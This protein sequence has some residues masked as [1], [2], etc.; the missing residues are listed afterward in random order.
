MKKLSFYKDSQTGEDIVEFPYKG[1]LL[2]K[3]PIVNK[4]S[5]FSEEE[6]VSFEL[7]GLLPPHVNTIHIQM[8]RAY[9][10][11]KEASTDLERHINLR[12]LQD[13]NETLFYAL[14]KE[15]ITEMMPIIYT[16]VVGEACK[17]FS[18]IYRQPRGLFISYP[19]R[20]QIDTIL[21]NALGSSI[22]IIVV[23]DGERILGLGDQ[24]IG[25]MG[26]PVGKLSL[27]TLCAGIHPLSTLPIMLDVGTN[28]EEKLK[29]PL[30]TGWQHPR[31]KGSEYEAF[32]DLFVQSVKRKFPQAL[33][34]WEDFAKHNALPL[35]NR[36][37]QELCSFNDDIQGTAAVALAGILSA[38]KVKK[39]TPKDEIYAFLGAGSAG[40][41]I[42][43][44][45]QME[46]ILNGLSQEEASSKIY[47]IDK[48]G[49]ITQERAFFE[50]LDQ[51]FAKSRSQISSW[52]IR[53]KGFITLVDVIQNAKITVLIGTTGY[54]GTFSKEAITL[55]CT[56][57]KRP[58]LF[59]L[60]NPNSQS[61]AAP[62]DLYE[63]TQGGAIIATG[64]PFPPLLTNEGPRIIGQCNNAYIFPGVGLGIT[65]VKAKYITDDIFMLAAKTLSQFSPALQAPQAPLF[66]PLE[67]IRDISYQIALNVAKECVISGL[68]DPIPAEEIEKRIKDKMWKPSYPKIKIVQ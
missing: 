34:Q 3:F 62:Q 23:T 20:D 68:A 49:L 56:Y 30:Y 31:L 44:L 38:T 9:E 1:R 37:K 40:L 35:L 10:Q 45:T 32:I 33:L 14:I 6:R 17:Q 15:H 47:L 26:I 24:G 36:Y 16:P 48:E 2:L 5:S 43:E 63:W 19:Q 66:P 7:Q 55:M 27:Y 61:E 60:S 46:L 50:G 65:S 64:S 67:S 42:A 25:G 59:P 18:H 52:N 22:E 57:E 4:G 8:Q 11:Y 13:R 41:A 21:D 53:E 29:D 51:K 54:P 12:N 28:N 39:S 58:I